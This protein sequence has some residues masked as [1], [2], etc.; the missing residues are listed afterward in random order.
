LPNVVLNFDVR[1]L[2]DLHIGVPQDALNV[3]VGHPEGVQVRCEPAAKS[4]PA[5]PD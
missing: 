2:R 4:V 1:L 3:N 5:A